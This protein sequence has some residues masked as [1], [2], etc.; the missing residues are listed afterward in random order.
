MTPL[1]VLTSRRAH[2]QSHSRIA[3]SLLFTFILTLLSL[4]A[5]QPAFAQDAP[6]AETDT[7]A[8][9]VP[10]VAIAPGEYLEIAYVDQLAFRWNDA[11]SDSDRD[12]SFWQPVVP[13]GWYALGSYG[14]GGGVGSAYGPVLVAKEIAPNSLAAPTGYTLIWA[15]YG[16]GSDNDGSFWK[17]DAPANYTCLGTVAQA[18]YAMPSTNAIRCVRTELTVAA[19]YDVSIWDDKGSGADS[20]FSA[21]GV[22]PLSEA[23]ADAGLT[24]GTFVGTNNYSQ[25]P[26]PAKT[27]AA[28]YVKAATATQ[29]EV[30]SMIATY[31]PVIALH[32]TEQYLPDSVDYV[33]NNG[34]TMC[35]GY[36]RNPNDYAT[37]RYD[38]T[39][40]Y[41]TNAAS[42][43]DT[44]ADS[45]QDPRFGSPDYDYFM[46]V[47]TAVTGGSMAR[48]KAYVRATRYSQAFVELQFWI[49]YPFNGSGKFYLQI[50]DI[51]S[52]HVLTDPTGRHFG[53]WE[54]VTVRLGK[55]A[56]DGI[57]KPMSF[58]MSRH[59]TN[60]VLAWRDPALL[61]YLTNHPIAF[62]ARDSHAHYPNAATQY[63]ERVGD[64]NI[65]VG[66]VNVDLED[67][68]A[69]SGPALGTYLPGKYEIVS[70]DFPGVAA[71]NPDWLGFFKRW[72]Q[73]ERLS[74][75]YTY[76]YLF[77]DYTYTQEEVGRGPTGPQTKSLWPQYDS[78]PPTILAVITGG[79]ANGYGWR[80]VPTTLSWSV[81][82]SQSPVNIKKYCD[83]I[84]LSNANGVDY[85][86]IAAS[87]GGFKTA[88]ARL[89]VD[90]TPPTT[91]VSS[92]QAVTYNQATPLTASWYSYDA[93]SGLLSTLATLDGNPVAQGQ[94]IDPAVG[95][96]TFTVTATDLAGNV[97]VTSVVFT[98]EASGTFNIPPAFTS[99][100]PY[101]V[102]VGSP[103]GYAITT[104]DLD[105][106]SPPTITAPV[107]PDFLTFVN[108]GNGTASLAGNPSAANLG[109]H[110]VKLLV[111]DTTGET[112]VQNFYLE[113]VTATAPVPGIVAGKVYVDKNKNDQVDP[114]EGVGT[115]EVSIEYAPIAAQA[116]GAEALGGAAAASNTTLSNPDGSYGFAAIPPTT[117]FVS[118]VAPVGYTMAIT[119][120]V[121]ITVQSGLTTTV[122]PQEV[123]A[124]GF[125]NPTAGNISGKI[126]A[127]ANGNKQPD[128][129]EGVGG[130]II[131]ADNGEA[132]AVASIDSPNFKQSTTSGS[133]GTYTFN[134]LPPGA[135]SL[136]FVAPEGYKLSATAPLTLNVTV[137]QTV[138]A[139]PFGVD[140]VYANVNL[141]VVVK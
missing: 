102:S 80:N 62:A 22:Y 96:H 83:P 91:N 78:T 46:Q 57:F 111:V 40:C 9:A 98:V 122:P 4:P 11:G 106:V 59:G 104:S 15:D 33:L 68:T 31:G 139:P 124:N 92:P 42:L 12:G 56:N 26:A 5:T 110:E 43:L 70:S 87:N 65:G 131:T 140:V 10:A 115:V 132:A 58:Y 135:Y 94:P 76:D 29:A 100:P 130:V 21:W 18:G 97:D 101:T 90:T 95:Q 37:F 69:Y 66:T 128:P 89:K 2:T 125:A 8:N 119:Q 88:T 1:S 82:D 126:F 116:A 112:D 50:G 79:S 133:D 44:V 85:R 134:E 13:P 123:I 120:P 39:L 6:P 35:R 129:G 71:T 63:Y 7:A 99:T 53:D 52:Y 60:Q 24:I 107:K 54:V 16:S 117:Y 67:W 73:N 75:A 17:P 64:T 114:D 84:T 136:S 93:V 86:C 72:G 141:P 113:V 121:L 81:N 48:A 55:D 41:T 77:S 34:T 49:Y 20:N 127:D 25:P 19:K 28:A 45:E 38:E 36:I 137:G 105:Q 3:L 108:N 118:F 14:I 61:K 27:L 32:P 47:N 51:E 74:F 109:V 30:N 103:Y 23:G 138:T